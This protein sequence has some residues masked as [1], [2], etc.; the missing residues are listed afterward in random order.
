MK[1]YHLTFFTKVL[2][3]ISL[4]VATSCVTSRGIKQAEHETLYYLEYYVYDYERF[5]I[6]HVASN[7][8]W[9]YNLSQSDINILNV[10]SLDTQF[11]IFKALINVTSL[12]K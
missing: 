5:A 1:T 4:L 2:V 12:D 7:G 10:D 8:D 3:L 9:T 11:D 6:D